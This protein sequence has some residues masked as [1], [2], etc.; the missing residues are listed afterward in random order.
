MI[1]SGNMMDMF[2]FEVNIPETEISNSE[3]EMLVDSVLWEIM[4]IS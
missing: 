4:K 3:F 2:F 1:T